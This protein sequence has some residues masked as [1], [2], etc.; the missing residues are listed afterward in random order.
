[1]ITMLK[2]PS[3]GELSDFGLSK[4]SKCEDSLRGA[5]R[6]DVVLPRV[7]SEVASN[8]QR[9]SGS[10]N[11]GIVLT[12]TG[13]GVGIWALTRVTSTAGQF[14]T[15][16]PPFSEYEIATLV[17]AGISAVLLIVGLISLT[18]RRSNVRDG[19]PSAPVSV[20]STVVASNGAVGATTLPG[21]FCSA[22]G[23]RLTEKAAFCPECGT[24]RGS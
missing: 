20:H 10:K 3:C 21:R 17:G 7:Q 11:L 13:L 12:V 4:C 19:Q 23:Q 8:D 15:W 9:G 14:F 6:V 5:E 22:C 16:S 24:K 2:C 18:S 1:M